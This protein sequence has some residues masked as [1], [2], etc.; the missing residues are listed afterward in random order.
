MRFLL[1]N[2]FYPP[3]VAPTGKYLHDLAKV[4]VRR[5]HEVQVWC[6]RCSYDGRQRFVPRETVDGVMVRR[7]RA[8]GFGRRGFI[9]KIFDYAS[10]YSA[11]LG[12]LLFSRWQPDVILSLTTPPYL[13]LLGKIGARRH[14]CHHAHWIMDLYPDVLFAQRKSGGLGAALL[15][16]LTRCQMQ[17][18]KCVM[19]LGP[20]MADKLSVYQRN[21]VSTRRFLRWMPLWSDAALTPWPE[22]QP[23][24]LRH[25]RGW[26]QEVV[27]LYSG[28][29]GV[30]HRFQEFL[31]AARRLGRTG[32]RWVFAG[33]GKRRA[34][35]E[36]FA[37]QHP[38]AGIQLL[39]YAPAALLREH[40]SAADVH[41]AS[42]DSNWQGLMA[43]SKL[44]GS[45]A[46]GRPVLFV[47][48]RS[49]ETAQWII[50]SGGGWVVAEEDVAAL[51]EAI[52]QALNVSERRRRGAAAWEFSRRHFQA[53]ENCL[54]I[55]RWLEA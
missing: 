51:S 27:F 45:F 28:N 55:A 48:S 54:Q 53:T 14:R 26:N 34:E 1:L 24:A 41:L 11:L 38:E 39:D 31:E 44:Q 19:T 37:R 40:L 7:L 15:R 17:G 9:G 22:Q 46:V 36:N 25:D 30:G 50:Q 16:L 42:L 29:M 8:T 13:G 23:N 20:T 4:L 43:P 47:G 35:I 10:F 5:G 12:A 6:S 49:S 32:P 18:A 21:E 2:Q 52:Q 33:G 3:D